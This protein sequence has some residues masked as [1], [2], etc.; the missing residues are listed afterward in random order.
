M[1]KDEVIKQ[2]RILDLP[3]EEYY[4]LSGASLVLRGIRKKCSDIDLC[5]SEELFNKE[6][7]NL[8]MTPDKLNACGFYQL[9]DILEIIV[10]KKSLFNMEEGEEF[11]YE[12]I[13]TILDFKKSRN[14]PKDKSDIIN[15]QKYLIK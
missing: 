12:N 3:K 15:I 8:G 9:S 11:N 7:N 13:N 4:V 14:L 2:L 5:I 6:K 10:D 1:N